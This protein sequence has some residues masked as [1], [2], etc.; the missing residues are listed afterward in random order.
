MGLS[1]MTFVPLLIE[2]AVTPGSLARLAQPVLELNDFVLRPWQ[3]SDA[4]AVA[5]AYSE[6]SIQHWHGRSMTEDE[7]RAWIDS[8]SGRW[9]RE[10]GCGWAVAVGSRLL[11]QISLRRLSLPDGVAELS[12]W[13][14]SA[15]RGRGLATRALRALSDWVFDQLCLHRVELN[16][17]VANPA[18]CRVAEKAGYAL[19]GIKR[20]EGLHVDGWHDMHLHARLIDDPLVEP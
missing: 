8:W 18:S 4:S 6:P 7:A 16:H 11:G 15:A 10:S 1:I 13:V 3:A 5:A 12:Y 19:E 20:R 9:N 14:A 2:P 17:S